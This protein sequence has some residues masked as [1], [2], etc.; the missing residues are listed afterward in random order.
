[1]SSLSRVPTL[2]D[3]TDCSLPGS[4]V[5]GIF[6]A[7]VLE[8]IAISFSR[9][10]S[11]PRDWTRV[12]RIAGR[13]FTVWVTREATKPY[14]QGAGKDRRQ[15]EKEATEDEIVGWHH[16]LNGHEF[17]QTPGDSEGQRSLPCCRPR[18]CKRSDTT[19]WLNNKDYVSTCHFNFCWIVRTEPTN[20][21]Y[22][23]F[24]GS[25][26]G[27]TISPEQSILI[28]LC[29]AQYSSFKNFSELKTNERI[30]SIWSQT[31]ENGKKDILH[32]E[33]STADA[34]K[35]FVKGQIVNILGF[36]GCKVCV[37]TL[38]LCLTRKSTLNKM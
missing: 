11:W 29:F 35:T 27:E 10:S 28:S 38:Q 24:D 16:Q 18:D 23:L 32:Q 12:S 3:P 17:E 7:T 1:M 9:G 14:K 26:K 6:Q 21:I 13:C 36:I 33:D 5:H 2:W 37:P 8:W 20:N 34:G 31:G 4:S 15:E 22:T 19:G 25:E 30:T